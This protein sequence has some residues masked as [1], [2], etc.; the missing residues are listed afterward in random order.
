MKNP[1]TQKQAEEV[2]LTKKEAMDILMEHV[3]EGK[4]DIARGR[5]MTVDQ[6]FASIQRKK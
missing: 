1:E 6:A 4:R 3:A 5:V 2:R